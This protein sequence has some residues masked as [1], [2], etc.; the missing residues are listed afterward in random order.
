VTEQEREQT[1]AELLASWQKD[2]R[3]APYGGGNFGMP[4]DLLLEDKGL[5]VPTARFFLRA[6]GPVPTIDPTTWRLRVS[7]HVARELT[8]S[9]SDL[10]S[11]P[12]RTLT[13]FLEC[14]GNSRT[15]YSPPA[16]GTP[17]RNDA[18]GNATWKGVNLAAVLD[19][20]GVG[21]DAVDVVC[22]GGD[23]DGMRR[24]LPIT[25]ARAAETLLV[26]R[27][28]GANLPAAHG[29]P[30]RLLV[31]GWAG[32][33]S[34]KWLVGLEVLDHAFAG[35]WNADNYVVWTEHGEAVRPIQEM[36]VKSIIAAPADGAIL[37]PGPRLLIGYAWSGHGAIRRVEVS[38]DGGRTWGEAAL[39]TAGRRS[40]VRF[41]YPWHATVGQIRLRARATDERGL[42][43]PTIATWNA[44]GYQM[45]AIHEVAVTVTT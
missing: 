20:A 23:F 26:W 45:N 21:V 19:L 10:Q 33:A 43:Q 8:I 16:E 44:K 36:P 30:V 5:I 18:A 3:L 11:L 2:P 9:L 27:M 40:W 39:R 28:N 41:E 13:A 25:V 15:R 1:P 34:T 32:I 22:Q 17:W 14:A 31:P 12:S 42:T 37:A 38:A 24:G 35:F 6:N 4:L 7:G 29:G